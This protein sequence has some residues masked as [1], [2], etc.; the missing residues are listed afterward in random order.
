MMDMALAI[1]QDPDLHAQ[2]LSAASMK[3]QLWSYAEYM[4]DG[5]WI[6]YKALKYIA[7]R[8]EEE[9]SKGN[10]RIVVNIPPRH[11]KS[12]LIS[13]WLPVWFLDLNPDKRV[14]LS[15]YG[16]SLAS[17]WGRKARDRIK[18]TPGMWVQIMRN[19]DS[20]SD[21]YTTDGGGMKTA[22]VGG[23][24]LGRGGD[25]I[26]IDDPHKN[27][28]EAFSPVIRKKTIDWFNSTLYSRCEPGGSIVL[29][30]QRWHESD[31]SGYLINEH[32][33]SWVNIKMPAM[34]EWEDEIG[35]KIGDPLVPERYNKKSLENIKKAV[36]SLF[37][38]GMYQQRPAPE[39]GNIIKKDWIRHWDRL[40]PNIKKVYV[41]WDMNFKSTGKSWCV[42]QAWYRKGSTHYL[43]AQE[44]GKWDFPQALKKVMSFNNYCVERWGEVA[45]TLIEEAA[46]GIGIIATLKNEMPR[47]KPIKASK[48]KI[49]RLSNASPSIECG[50]V[51]FPPKSECP[52]VEDLIHELITF[53]NGEND[54]QCDALSQ[55]INEFKLKKVG[56]V[57]LNLGIGHSKSAWKI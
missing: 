30:M 41:T 19:K 27:H 14:I 43:L 36:G 47:I 33:D 35:R 39:A 40:P 1:E 45:T 24:I 11:G 9:L 51:L 48:S 4:S 42:G 10:A 34:A 17:D 16:D 5:K 31:L 49:E 25:L 22:G 38:A 55:Y 6:A 46:N 57:R 2:L 3:C 28:E 13:H 7:T 23:P 15:S 53:P 29:I 18:Y 8:I 50:D 20:A 54:D 12:E 52:W 26:V 32:P 44:R 37:W 21:W 56:D